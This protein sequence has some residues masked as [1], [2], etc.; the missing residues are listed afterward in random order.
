MV[1]RGSGMLAV[2]GLAAN[3]QAMA[4]LLVLPCTSSVVRSA[5]TPAHD[6][7]CMCVQV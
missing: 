5:V 3:D 1:R 7:A 2:F 6:T 4:H